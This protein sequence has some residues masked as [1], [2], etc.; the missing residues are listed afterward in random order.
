MAVKFCVATRKEA[1]KMP[2]LSRSFVYKLR[3]RFSMVETLWWY[4]IF[5]TKKI[6]FVKKKRRNKEQHV[7]VFSD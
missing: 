5:L 3:S 1:R 6:N 7:L 2:K 4:L